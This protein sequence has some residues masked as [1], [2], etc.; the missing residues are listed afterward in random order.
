MK[1]NFLKPESPFQTPAAAK[2]AKATIQGSDDFYGACSIEAFPPGV[3][4]LTY[5]HEDAQG[6]LDFVT[7][8]KAANFWMKD[9]AVQ[10][11]AYEE[12]NDNWQD[13]YGADAVTAFYHSGHGNMDSNGVFQAPMGG[14][15]DNRNWAFSNAMGLGDEQVRYLFWSTCYSLRVLNG[16]SPVRTWHPANKGLRMIFGYETTSVDDPNYGKYFW[17]EWNKG[18]TFAQSWLDASRR[19]SNQQAPAVCATGA[20]AQE[21]LGRLNKERL[22]EAAPGSNKFYQWTWYNAAKAAALPVRAAKTPAKPMAALFAPQDAEALCY[23]LAAALGASKKSAGNLSVDQAGN[24]ILRDKRLRLLVGANGHCDIHFGQANLENDRTLDQTKARQ[25]AE[26]L[27]SALGVDKDVQLTLADVVHRHTQGASAQGS[28]SIDKSRVVETIVE[29]R[30]TIDGLRTVSNGSGVVRVGVDNDGNITSFHNSTRPVA[31]LSE[32]PHS[33]AP[34]P[35]LRAAAPATDLEQA[36]AE[37]LNA[38]RP[39]NTEVARAARPDDDTALLQSEIG[40]DLFADR[41]QL[42][43]RRTYELDMGEGFKKL[44]KLQV[45]LVD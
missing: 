7:K 39:A 6:F 3:G 24:F 18:K 45:P 31:S 5:T 17:E 15:W 37:K 8:S 23:R 14:T 29:F 32:K 33:Q 36:F 38:L 1:V 27:I 20:T 11:W 30:Q 21:A 12:A 34:V 10:V 22:F 19:I 35:G 9:A 2:T 40:Y 26:S 25:T 13:T 41:G 43:A 16:H 28:G 42:V 44:Y 4:N